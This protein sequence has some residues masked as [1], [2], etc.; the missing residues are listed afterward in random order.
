[1]TCPVADNSGPTCQRGYGFRRCPLGHWVADQVT[2]PERDR[3]RER[4]SN[5]DP[6]GRPSGMAAAYPGLIQPVMDSAISTPQ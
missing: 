3:H 4:V 2:H 5:G 6:Q 1:M